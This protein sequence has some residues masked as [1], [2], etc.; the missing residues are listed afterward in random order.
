MNA[1]RRIIAVLV[2]AALLAA[3][4]VFASFW[5]LKQVE[6]ASL[7]REHTALVLS[8][9][10][11]LQNELNASET[12]VRG[13]LLTGDESFLEP[14]LAKRGGFTGRARD[15]RE[16]ALVPEVAQHMAVLGPLV[17]ERIANLD[18][19]T[20]RYRNQGAAAA[21]ALVTSGEGQRLTDSI[22][23]EIGSI[24]TIEEDTLARREAAVDASL[25][26]MLTVLV[27]FS[28]FW[29]LLAVLF[30]YLIYREGQQQRQN[31]LHLET[32]R[33][34]EVQEEA[35]QQLRQ[36]NDTLLVSEQKLAVTLNSIGDA[37]IATDAQGNVEL[38][39]PLAE[40]LTGWARQ[41]ATGRPIGEIFHIVNEE[42]R[43]PTLNPVEATLAQGTAHDMANHTIVVA[44]DGRECAIAD[45][46]A[47]I[48]DRDGSVV[49]AVLVFRDVTERNRLD[50]LLRLNNDE[51][52]RAR[53]V[54]E[55]ANLAK[56]EFL[57]SMSHE[58]RSPLNAVLGFAQL[59][60]SDSPPPTADQ[61]ASI[62]QILHAGWHL[63]KLIDEILDLT[64][65]ESGQVPLS[66]EPVP[67][68]AVLVECRGMVEPP[69]RERHLKLDFPPSEVPYFVR[70]DKT[71]VTQVLVNLLS[72]AVK[73]NSDQGT[74]KVR[75]AETAPGR[76][77]V[78]VGD[79]GAGLSPPQLEQLFQ[80][81]NRLGQEAGGV[82]GTGIGLVVARQLVELMGGT[83][84][85]ES[86]VGAGSVFWFELSSVAAPSLKESAPSAVPV[87]QRAGS[88]RR[89]TLLYV[90]DNPANLQLVEQ[91]IERHPDLRLLT[92]VSG[93]A[94]IAV[95]RE[96]QPDAIL[97][98]INL[99]DISGLEALRLL[100]AYPGTS[101]IPIVA[102]SANAMPRDIK[103]GLDAGFFRYITKPIMVD[104]FMAALDVVLEFADMKADEA[105]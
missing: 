87:N 7:A 18:L 39:N 83:M 15:L 37:V 50:K 33:V 99:P 82:E 49:G 101:H 38:L 25:R 105:S 43:E 60:K 65:I 93:H 62:D 70:A 95:A 44:R 77:R 12:S 55:E 24:R 53:T 1:S 61:Q 103:K 51:L 32:A 88:G 28:V 98:D 35:N 8:K 47:P 59:M 52:G 74:I 4:G 57:S 73:Y 54:A 97:M 71:R 6:K 42:T 36:A 78:S 81:F 3:L 16:L 89:H 69:A 46:C 22:R 96:S 91:I 79:T 68:E 100:R 30:A 56:S 31:S 23:T 41:E 63:L 11:E 17:D 94:G 19:V 84:G 64:R 72:N 90:E 29:L 2:A 58:L 26:R 34:L 40:K 21:V 86:T 80:A 9:A 104:E 48:R 13:Y 10:N 27:L 5:Y 20:A 67:L 92:A 85:V 14:Y 45:S 102:V 76:V 75:C 66:L